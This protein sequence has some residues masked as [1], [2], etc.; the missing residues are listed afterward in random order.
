[1]NNYCF[2]AQTIDLTGLTRLVISQCNQ[3]MNG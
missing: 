1:M 3:R 2:I